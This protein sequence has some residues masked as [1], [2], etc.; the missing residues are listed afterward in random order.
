MKRRAVLAGGV[1]VALVSSLAGCAGSDGPVGGTDD[2]GAELPDDDAGNRPDDGTEPE[3]E[4]PIEVTPGTFDDFE[5]PDGW[6]VTHGMA[7]TDADRSAVGSQSIRFEPDEGSDTVALERSFDTPRDLSGLVP[8]LAIAASA[9]VNP[10]IQ[11][12]DADGDRI[13]YRCVNT[14]GD[15]FARYNFGVTDVIGDPDPTA[16][17]SIRI[18]SWAVDDDIS[19]WIDDLHFV[20]QPETGTVLLQFDREYESIETVARHVLGEYGYPATV[21]AETHRVGGGGRVDTDTFETLHDDGWT[22]ASFGAYGRNLLQLSEAER[23]EELGAA[24]D[25]LVDHGFDDGARYFAYPYSRYDESVIEHVEAYYDLAF[26]TGYP[27]QGFV[28]N[29]YTYG[30]SVGADPDEAIAALD[31]TAD[32]GGITP[33]FFGDVAEDVSGFETVIEHLHDRERRGDLEVRLPGDLE[34]SFLD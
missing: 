24:T 20:E 18:R 11:L 30:R 3:T 22:I 4:D 28:T 2:S 32:W 17:T 5:E 25:W 23:S 1:G 19:F 9:S 29:P 13:D 6:R 31:A 15:I 12:Q 26:A 8:G 34:A 21:F 7:F 33:L 10:V 14:P 27:A 16:I